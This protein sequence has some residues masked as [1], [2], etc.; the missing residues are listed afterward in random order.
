MYYQGVAELL[1]MS[2]FGGLINGDQSLER[3]Y[4]HVISKLSTALDQVVFTK[5]FVLTLVNVEIEST[6]FPIQT[7]ASLF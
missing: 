3:T 1:T 5:C 7:L 4:I 6:L 2:L